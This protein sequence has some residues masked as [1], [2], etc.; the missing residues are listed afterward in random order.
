MYFIRWK[1]GIVACISRIAW[2]RGATEYGG[3]WFFTNGMARFRLPYGGGEAP[4]LYIADTSEA[5]WRKEE[6]PQRDSLAR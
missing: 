2:D 4:A 1:S 5:T 3:D 6:V